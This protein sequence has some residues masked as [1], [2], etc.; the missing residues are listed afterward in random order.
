[1]IEIALEDVQVGAAD[2]DETDAQQRLI[3]GG[4]RDISRSRPEPPCPLVECRAHHHT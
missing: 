3:G 1:M 2:P 4:N